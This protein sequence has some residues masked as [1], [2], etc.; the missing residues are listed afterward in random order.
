MWLIVIV[1]AVILLLQAMRGVKT[2]TRD[3]E[4]YR[5]K[6]KMGRKST[7]NLAEEL[8]APFNAFWTWLKECSVHCWFEK[9]WDLEETVS[10]SPSTMYGTI[11]SR[12]P[13]N[14]TIKKGTPRLFLITITAMF[15]LWIAQWLFWLGFIGLSM[16]EYV[17]VRART[18]YIL[19]NCTKVLSPQA[20]DSYRRLDDLLISYCRCSSTSVDQRV[21][22]NQGTFVC[23]LNKSRKR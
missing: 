10:T 6:S 5:L 12:V 17:P 20:W 16:E 1:V 7:S 11:S 18:E 9:S 15:F 21:L 2:S 23:W 14:S 19:A 8:T 3:V 22:G 13:K 4:I